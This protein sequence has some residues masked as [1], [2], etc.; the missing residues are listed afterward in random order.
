MKVKSNNSSKYTTLAIVC[1]IVLAQ[2]ADFTEAMPILKSEQL[3]EDTI[4]IQNRSNCRVNKVKRN[5]PVKIDEKKE[6]VIYYDFMCDAE[7][8]GVCEQVKEA[9]Q[10]GEELITIYT[11]CIHVNKHKDGSRAKTEPELH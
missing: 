7:E 2:I 8:G 11:A 10:V 5:V 3:S 9:V 6:K 1:L 4:E